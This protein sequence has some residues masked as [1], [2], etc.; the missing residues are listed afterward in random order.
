MVLGRGFAADEFERAF[1]GYRQL[2]NAEPTIVRCSPDVL[3][4]FAVLFEGGEAAAGDRTLRYSGVPLA[5]AILAPGTV[6]F[7]GEVDENRMGDW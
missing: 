1:L 3:D 5:A 2:Y 7:E 6:A 4:R